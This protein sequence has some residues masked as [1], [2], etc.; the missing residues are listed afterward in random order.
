VP[1]GLR[2][3]VALLVVGAAAE[4]HFNGACCRA[5]EIQV[6]TSTSHEPITVA[7][8]SCE[9]WQEGVYDVWHL[10]GNCYVNQGLT[11]ARG[12]EAVLW[13]DAREFPQQ[14]I[15][16]I[17]YFEA[18]GDPKVSVDY[19]NVQNDPAKNGVLGKQFVPTWFQ[20]FE[21][22]APLKWKLPRE[23]GAPQERPA[24]YV[25][26]LEQFNPDHR[27]QLLLAQYNEFAPAPAA[28]HAEVS[29]VSAQRRAQ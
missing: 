15:R 7:A 2:T 3:L 27:R 14:P 19:G 4:L 26:G 8:D 13:V 6:A 23:S 5:D 16:V 1:P 22:T 24:I 17:A 10:R 25:R 28:G 11:Y 21:T 18:G 9:H 29:M 20:R 12:G